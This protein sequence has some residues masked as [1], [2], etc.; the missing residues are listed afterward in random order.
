MAGFYSASIDNLLAAAQVD[1]DG[2]ATDDSWSDNDAPAPTPLRASPIQIER[3]N[4]AERRR[5]AERRASRHKRNSLDSAEGNPE[6]IGLLD[7]TEAVI[8]LD[9]KRLSRRPSFRS[10]LQ[11]PSS[12]RQSLR[13][14]L[15]KL[16]LNIEDPSVID[17]EKELKT[18]NDE[19]DISN[20][21]TVKGFRYDYS[22]RRVSK[23]VLSHKE[24]QL[25]ELFESLEGTPK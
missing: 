1:S 2:D 23:E 14:T 4:S 24:R 7:S 6:N 3:R 21:D 8:P 25:L 5:S 11:K 12:S 16:S 20:N 10:S 9:P 22:G 13:Y 19:E 18:E 17:G 15:S